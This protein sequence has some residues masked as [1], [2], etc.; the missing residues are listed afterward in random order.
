MFYIAGE[1][2]LAAGYLGHLLRLCP[3]YDRDTLAR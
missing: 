2:G 3:W 1:G